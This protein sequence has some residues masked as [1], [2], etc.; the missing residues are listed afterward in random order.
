M[1]LQVTLSI[2]LLALLC[3]ACGDDDP[4]GAGPGGHDSG[5][6]DGGSPDS[7]ATGGGDAT[8]GDSSDSGQVD[9]SS[10]EAGE[11]DPPSGEWKSATSN[12]ANLDS[13]CGNLTGLA[14]SPEGDKLVAGV[15]L[16]GLWSSTDGGN[17]WVALGDSPESDSIVNRPMSIVFDPANAEWFWESG[18]YNGGGAYVT[19][20]GGATFRSLGVEVH[21]DAIS[22]DFSDPE[23]AVLLVGGHE[24]A[25][26]LFRSDDGGETWNNIGSGLPSD[27]SCTWPL[28]IDADTYLVG[29][30]YSGD[31]IYR[32]SD[33]GATWSEVS[34]IGGSGVPLVASDGSIY[35]AMKDGGGIVRSTDD[36]L[37]WTQVTGPQVVESLGPVEL[38]DGRIAAVGKTTIVAS[39]DEGATWRPVSAMLPYSDISGFVYSAPQR[40]FF[41]K[42]FTCGS[43]SVPV[44]ADAIMRFDYDFEQ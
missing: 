3:S 30:S 24:S 42:H 26:T 40:A 22:V 1:R 23:R 18:I 27:E 43:E 38:P 10:G 44:P 19:D 35:W 25:Q 41:I 2:G 15:A 11:Q 20:N 14:V 37:T 12:L 28:V 16:Q 32:S 8:V 21:G 6:T 31:G 34:P 33:A 7:A 29:C 5:Q 9:S 4:G 36:G 17:S 39:A 13:E